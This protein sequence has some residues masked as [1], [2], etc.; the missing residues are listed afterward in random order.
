MRSSDV[1]NRKKGDV[2]RKA[3]AVGSDASARAPN[4]DLAMMQ[5]RRERVRVR[6]RVRV[7]V[8]AVLFDVGDGSRYH[9]LTRSCGC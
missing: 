7:I 4:N 6:V 2:L 8:M 9:R 3:R 5:R 1:E